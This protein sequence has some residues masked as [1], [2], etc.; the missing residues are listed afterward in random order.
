MFIHK[1]SLALYT[2]S[3]FRTIKFFSKSGSAFITKK[4]ITFMHKI[5]IYLHKK[6]TKKVENN[7]DI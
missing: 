6:K 5:L 4:F 2:L 7:S 3:I 1:H